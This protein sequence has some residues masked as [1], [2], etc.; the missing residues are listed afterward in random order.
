M[1]FERSS[2]VLLHI[3]SLPGSFGIGDLGRA[4]RE[5]VD[6]LAAA[7]QTI[8]QILPLCPPAKGNSPYSSYAVFAG[9]PLLIS[10]EQMELDGWIDVSVAC[11]ELKSLQESSTVNFARA[12]EWKA[13]IF[14]QSFVQ[15]KSKLIHREDFR[16]FCQVNRFWL[17]EFSLFDALSVELNDLDWTR[18]PIG[19][20][21]RDPRVLEQWHEQIADRVLFSKYLQF[22]FDQQWKRLKSYANE[23]RVLIFGDLPIFVALESV[24]VWAN[25]EQY[26]LNEKGYPTSV[27]GV[28]PD[29]FSPTGQRWGNPL[30]CW[31][32]MEKDGFRWWVSRFRR[33]LEQFDMI[34]VDH[35]RGFE[36]YWEIPAESE[37]AARGQWRKGPGEKPF[38]AACKQLGELP[39]IAEDLGLITEAVHQLRDKLDLPC[40]R[41]LQFGFDHIEDDFHRPSQYPEHCVAYTGTHDNE[42]VMGWYGNRISN[43]SAN[44]PVNLLTPILNDLGPVHLQLIEMVMDSKANTAIFPM[45]DILGLGNESRMNLPATAEGNWQWRLTSKQLSVELSDRLNRI[46]RSSGRR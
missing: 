11:P 21:K 34:R 7:G 46:T 39:L 12:Q 14:A 32:A 33:L 45:Q 38:K 27:A 9:N 36:S 26:Q 44:D 23:N 13:K 25:Q 18:W 30:Y 19:L 20:S 41:V 1:R 3:T 22:V 16:S 28:P 35:F 40:T 6:F 43:F 2:G 8:W 37:S 24:D 17:D 4:S 15:S 29:Y 42:T 31:E 10:V 5:F